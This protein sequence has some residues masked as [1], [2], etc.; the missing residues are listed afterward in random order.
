[1]SILFTA[2]NKG[3]L[4]DLLAAL[5]QLTLYRYLPNASVAQVEALM[6]YLRSLPS[7]DVKTS[8]LTDAQRVVISFEMSPT[9]GVETKDTL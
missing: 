5:L 9:P 4:L 6:T 2:K 1:M 3:W 8:I 7:L